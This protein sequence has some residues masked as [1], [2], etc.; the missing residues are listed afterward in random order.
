[1]KQL[2]AIAGAIALIPLVPGAASAGGGCHGDYVPDAGTTKVT[3]QYMCMNPL[4]TRVAKKATVRWTNGDDMTHNITGAAFAWGSDGELRRGE[5][6]AFRFDDDG[7]FPYACTLHPGMIGAVVVGSGLRAIGT[8]PTSSSVTRVDT[9]PAAA[10]ASEYATETTPPAATAEP[11]AEPTEDAS[12]SA[13]A[14]AAPGEPTPG[15]PTPGEP[16]AIAT[17]Q[18]SDTSNGRG[19]L[20]MGLFAA[21]GALALAAVTFAARRTPPSRELLG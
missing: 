3:L 6:V 14:V 5:H 19:G 7:V 11:V 10:V 18:K 20:M 17:R 13:A 8:P 15:E 2:L 9:G 1:M 4:V 21:V 12:S 16:R